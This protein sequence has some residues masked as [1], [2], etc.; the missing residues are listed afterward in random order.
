MIVVKVCVSCAVLL[1]VVWCC[2]T[3]IPQAGRF[4]LTRDYLPGVLSLIPRRFHQP[5]VWAGDYLTRELGPV[6]LVPVPILPDCRDG[7]RQD[8]NL[9]HTV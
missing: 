1:G 8:S 3:P 2:S 4:W 9:R 6:R 7:F 5:G